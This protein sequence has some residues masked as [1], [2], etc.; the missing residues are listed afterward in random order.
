MKGIILAGGRGTRL[1][2]M[3]RSVSKQ[4]LPVYDKPLIYYP[5]S[6][7]MLARIREVLVISK[8]E[9]Q[10][11]FQGL[12]GTGEAWGLS[13]SYAVQEEPRGLAESFL[14]GRDFI[15]DEP[16]GL[17]LGDN[18]LYGRGLTE[19]LRNAGQLK[20]G[21]MIFGYRVRDPSRYGIIALDEQ[22]RPIS[23]EEKPEKPKS[24]FAVPGLYFYDASVV[25]IAESLEPSARGELEIT[26]INNTYLDGGELQ[27]TLLGRGVAW[28]DAGTP[29]A[30]L[31]AATFVRALEDR[32]GMKI[33]CVEEIA[34]R[35]GFIEAA[36]LQELAERAPRGRYSD[37]L[38]KM[39]E[40][41]GYGFSYR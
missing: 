34:Y 27:V 21:A 17:V 22:L 1:Y 31:E 32:Q 20:Q 26:D 13:F 41:E 18:I 23:I 36:Q 24:H 28:L 2:P 12:L 8:P 7:L 5:L 9:D 38:M 35:L 39:L 19:I 10:L 6:V 4:L 30:L 16:V 37:Y 15:G 11:S 25:G 29:D 40:E 33:S 14:I 3:T